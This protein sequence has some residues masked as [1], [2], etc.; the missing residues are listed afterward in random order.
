MVE[1]FLLHV[2]ATDSGKEGFLSQKT[3]KTDEGIKVEFVPQLVE[4]NPKADICS[5]VAYYTRRPAEQTK[6]LVA[7]EVEAR[8]PSIGFEIEVV[9]KQISLQESQK[10]ANCTWTYK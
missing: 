7:D 10:M 5:V 4:N 1:V 9:T 6:D 3:R 2:K 8:Y